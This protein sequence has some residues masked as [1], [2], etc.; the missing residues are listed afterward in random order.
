MLEK[1]ILSFYEWSKWEA[2][3]H[4]VLFALI[5]YI[6]YLFVSK[7]SNRTITNILLMTIVVALDTIIHQ[8]I[9]IK[10]NKHTSYL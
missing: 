4:H 5:I 9:N 1:Q 8:N 6:L 2:I 3:S 7:K 10:N